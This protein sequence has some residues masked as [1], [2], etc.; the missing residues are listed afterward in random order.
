MGT[1]HTPAGITPVAPIE[2]YQGWILVQTIIFPVNNS[3]HDLSRYV[4]FTNTFLI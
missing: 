4:H 1:H 2:L 3:L